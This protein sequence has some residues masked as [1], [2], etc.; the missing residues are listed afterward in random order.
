MQTRLERQLGTQLDIQL[1]SQLTEE[2]KIELCRMDKPEDQQLLCNLPHMTWTLWMTLGQQLGRE[3]WGFDDPSLID[4]MQWASQWN[5]IDYCISVL[6]CSCDQTRWQAF[7]TLTQECGWVLPYEK[8]CLVC[9]RPTYI[10]FDGNCPVYETGQ[11]VMQYADGFT[12]TG[13]VEGGLELRSS[14]SL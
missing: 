7:Q 13:T 8:V 12:I 4:P 14:E 11:A 10:S 1:S 3:W 9:D 2:L 6:G 5:W